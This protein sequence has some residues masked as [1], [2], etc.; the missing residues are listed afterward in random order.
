LRWWPLIL[1]VAG[2]LVALRPVKT[3]QAPADKFVVS[4]APQLR[5]P[6][7][8]GA[9]QGSGNQG[10]GTNPPNPA[11][12]PA[13]KNKNQGKTSTTA[14]PIPPRGALGEYT[15]PAPGASVE[16]LPDNE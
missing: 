14:A 13:G 1:V 6:T 9:K 4:S 8:A 10:Y 5:S 15:Q 12:K 2:V 11:E 16:I 3:V 7:S